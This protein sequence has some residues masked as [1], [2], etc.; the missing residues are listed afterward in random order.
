M[1][2]QKA[3]SGMREGLKDEAGEGQCMLVANPWLKQVGKS[4]VSLIPIAALATFLTWP[5]FWDGVCVLD[6][7]LQFI[8]LSIFLLYMAE[9]TLLASFKKSKTDVGINM[10]EGY[11]SWGDKLSQSGF[12]FLVLWKLLHENGKKKPLSVWVASTIHVTWEWF[13]LRLV[14]WEGNSEA[15]REGLWVFDRHANYWRAGKASPGD[16]GGCQEG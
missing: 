11:L 16:L 12:F 5:Q 1:V 3:S 2:S 6:V 14:C 9:T 13:S 15:D 7:R 10:S 8:I 4:K